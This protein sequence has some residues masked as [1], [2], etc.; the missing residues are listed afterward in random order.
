MV[1]C[2]FCSAEIP[3]RPQA[4]EHAVLVACS[5]CKNP[6]VLRREG[7][8]SVADLPQ[9]VRD[10]REQAREGS[11]G[12]AILKL[13]PLV[14]E[15]L[16]VLPEIAHRVVTMTRDPDVSMGDLAEVIREDQ[17]IAVGVLQ[18]ANS[19]AYGGMTEIKDL[20][21]ACSRLG[22]KTINNAVQA[23]ANRRVYTTTNPQYL[24][25]MQN[26]WHHALATAYCAHEIAVLLAEPGADVFFIAGLIHDIGKVPLL[27]M[28]ANEDM[29]AFEPLRQSQEVFE[30]VL[31]AYYGLIGLQVVEHWQLP[32]EF[33]VAAFC[34]AQPETAPDEAWLGLVHTVSLASEVADLSGFGEAEGDVSLMGHPSAR[35]LGLN[36]LKLA[37]LRV[38]LEDKLAPYLDITKAS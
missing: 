29:P 25:M 13:L 30:E 23:I 37:G 32:A 19:A 2:P 3:L 28:V 9:G 36:D 17:V 38:D 12:E 6:V 8:K 24:A 18:M 34:H 35:Y 4:G 15:R 22:M 20:N 5:Q 1:K 16:P 11:V 7:G 33:A 27:D 10:I 26:L 14:I 31:E 21:A